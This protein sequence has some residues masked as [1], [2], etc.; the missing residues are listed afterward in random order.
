MLDGGGTGGPGAEVA[1]PFGFSSGEVLGI[2]VEG[3]HGLARC[4]AEYNG[5]GQSSFEYPGT[6]TRRLLDAV[7][8]GAMSVGGGVTA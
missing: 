5:D 3:V 4:L 8:R 2:L 6:I 7:M 1:G